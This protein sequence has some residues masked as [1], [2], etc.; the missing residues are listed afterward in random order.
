MAERKLDSETEF[1][2]ECGRRRLAAG[3]PRFPPP[4]VGDLE[5]VLQL[6]EQLSAAQV[7]ER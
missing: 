2:M 3:L 7:P 1:L 4:G 6:R 5:E